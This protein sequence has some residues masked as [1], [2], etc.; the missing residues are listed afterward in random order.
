MFNEPPCPAGWSLSRRDPIN[1]SPESETEHRLW[2]DP[3]GGL[4]VSRLGAKA[5][6]RYR[7]CFNDEMTF[8]VQTG[9]KLIIDWSEK[10][11]G[12]RSTKSHALADQLYPRILAHDGNLVLHAGAFEAKNGCILVV[13]ASGRGKSSLVSS[14]DQAGFPLLGDD[15][16]VISRADGLHLA[17]AVYPSLRLFPDSINALLK[18]NV[19]MSQVAHYTAKQRIDIPVSADSATEPVPILAMF[20]LLDPTAEANIRL[21]R[22]SVAESCMSLVE[23]SFA[24]DPS[25]GCSAAQR[26][27]LASALAC[28]VQAFA[29]SYPRDYTKLPAVR[30]AILDQCMKLRQ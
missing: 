23:N 14:F 12:L 5:A 28:Q 26:L 24:L 20:M 9:D 25:D 19:G 15:A 29:I 7:L 30:E 4:T 22:L 13:G 10:D 8:E 17:K 6:G 1:S 16:L 18:E 21:E 11:P 2:D 27:E 3:A